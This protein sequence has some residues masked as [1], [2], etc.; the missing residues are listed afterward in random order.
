MEL[1]CFDVSD[2][3]SGGDGGGEWGASGVDVR[4]VAGLGWCRSACIHWR[5]IRVHRFADPEATNG[6]RKC[7]WGESDVPLF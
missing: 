5:R 7:C 2:A 4:G 6:D 1:L 3:G